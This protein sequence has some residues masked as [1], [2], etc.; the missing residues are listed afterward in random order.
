MIPYEQYKRVTEVL[1]ILCVDVVVTNSSGQYL[2]IKRVNEPRKGQWWVIGGRV[3]KDETLEQA[4]AR[5]VWEEAS[6]KIQDIKPIGYYEEFSRANPFGL[7]TPYHAVSVV[8][9]TIVNDC[10]ALKLDDQSTAWKFAKDLPA[11]FG[12]RKF[13]IF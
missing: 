1:P 13:Q 8:F 10:I 11:D 12:V 4:V 2:L 3:Y 5:K 9:V 6:L 7:T